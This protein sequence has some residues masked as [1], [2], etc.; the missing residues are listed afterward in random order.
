MRQSSNRSRRFR[1][2]ALIAL[3]AGA[4]VAAGAAALV[5]LEIGSAGPERHTTLHIGCKHGAHGL[6]WHARHGKS[7]SYEPGLRPRTP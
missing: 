2:F 1:T 7:F 5:A 4:I 3:A 6:A